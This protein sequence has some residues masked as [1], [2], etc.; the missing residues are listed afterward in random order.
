[1]ERVRIR[2]AKMSIPIDPLSPDLTP[3]SES[4]HEFITYQAEIHENVMNNNSELRLS[5]DELKLSI[6]KLKSENEQLKS[7]NRQLEGK[8][9][10]LSIHLEKTNTMEEQFSNMELRSEQ[11]NAEYK[12]QINQYE[13]MISELRAENATMKRLGDAKK[14]KKKR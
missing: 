10:K 6:D 2:E 5:I 7:E 1:M 4:L 9:S 12:T 14:S 8:V 3:E 13:E 11:L